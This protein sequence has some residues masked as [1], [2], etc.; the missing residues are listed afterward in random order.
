MV[1]STC[2]VLKEENE[3]VVAAALKKGGVQLV[4]ID[5]GAFEG[6]PLLPTALPG[7]MCVCPDA[8]YEGFFV[9]KLRKTAKK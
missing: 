4:P 3:D 9:A 5:A 8:L 6:V 1:Y 7:V 2:S